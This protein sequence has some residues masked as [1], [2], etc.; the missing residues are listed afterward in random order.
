MNRFTYRT[1]IG[2]RLRNTNVRSRDHVQR[3]LNAG[4]QSRIPRNTNARSRYQVQRFLNTLRL[5]RRPRNTNGQFQRILNTRGQRQRP[6]ITNNRPRDQFQSNIHPSIDLFA[7]TQQYTDLI[8]GSNMFIELQ[9]A[10]IPQQNT[11]YQ[12]GLFS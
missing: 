11:Q 12:T 4:R 9:D 7:S 5:F 3:I 2:Q 6:H 10:E 1:I 8:E